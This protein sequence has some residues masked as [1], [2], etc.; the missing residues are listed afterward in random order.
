M[1]RNEILGFLDLPENK[2]KYQNAK[3]L[4]L[5]NDKLLSELSSLDKEK[6]LYGLKIINVKA[7]L[8]YKIN[9]LKFIK[10]LENNFSTF[11]ACEVL[12]NKTIINSGSAFLSA[13]VV[14]SSGNPKMANFM[15][16]VLASPYAIKKGVSLSGAKMIGEYESIYNANISTILYYNKDVVNSNLV[17]EATKILKN[18]KTK[19]QAIK[20][21]EIFCN[22]DIIKLIKEKETEAINLINESKNNYNTVYMAELINSITALKAGIVLEGVKLI[23]EL[24]IDFKAEAAMIT[25]MLCNEKLIKKGNVLEEVRNI[26]LNLKEKEFTKKKKPE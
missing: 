12:S 26:V 14:I 4:L 1:E 13:E 11:E 18:S 5:K 8:S 15:H 17:L 10:E 2:V 22:K 21:Y 24:D 9:A 25:Y 3:K 19:L 23:N 16:M 7:N 6:F 20:I